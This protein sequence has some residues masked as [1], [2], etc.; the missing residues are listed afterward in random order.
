[1]FSRAI[2]QSLENIEILT[3]SKNTIAYPKKLRAVYPKIWSCD[4]T[5]SGIQPVGR[6]PILSHVRF[7]I[8][9]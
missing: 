4:A 6:E 7:K 8:G 2:S 3:S 1:M 5:I 9:S